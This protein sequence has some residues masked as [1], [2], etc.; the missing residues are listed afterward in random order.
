MKRI[1]PFTKSKV[2]QWEDIYKNHEDLLYGGEFKP[3]S[4]QSLQ[5]LAIII[6]YKDRE[7]HLKLAIN[8]L[9][10]VLKNQKIHYKVFVA[11]Q[12]T[13][14]KFNKAALMDAAFLETRKL[15]QFDCLIFHDVDMLLEDGRLMYNCIDSPKHMGAYV[16]K[17][18]YTF[19][20]DYHVGG[21]LA[22][23]P[24]QFK[25]ANGYHLL[26]YGWGDEDRD[27]QNR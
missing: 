6:P 24:E 16:Q 25:R 23:T 19:P 17:F 11:E 13:P 20:G 26:F 4:C 7:E 27:M 1:K 12:A 22:I 10:Y 18:N 15:F 14:V 2:L 3:T 21:V 5:R 8:H 9:H